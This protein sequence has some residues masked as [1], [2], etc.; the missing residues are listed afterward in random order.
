MWMRARPAVMDMGMACAAKM[1]QGSEG[2]PDAE[3]QVVYDWI[4]GGALP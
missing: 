2:L 4:A 1:P 3:A